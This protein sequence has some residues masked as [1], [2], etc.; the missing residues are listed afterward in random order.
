MNGIDNNN[1]ISN[2]NEDIHTLYISLYST[3][4]KQIYDCQNQMIEDN[5]NMLD[6]TDDDQGKIILPKL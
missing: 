6:K 3:V 5:I 1:I 4:S 2:Q